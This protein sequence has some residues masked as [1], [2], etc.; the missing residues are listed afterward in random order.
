MKKWLFA[1]KLVLTK[2]LTALS[3]EIYM[4]L[5]YISQGYNKTMG[6]LAHFES[7]FPL[8]S[9]RI[10]NSIDQNNWKCN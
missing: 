3:N 4:M 5:N 2:G 7:I 10:N 1:L 8:L 9:Y 6:L